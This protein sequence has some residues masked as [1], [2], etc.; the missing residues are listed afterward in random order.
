MGMWVGR[1]CWM[2]LPKLGCKRSTSGHVANSVAS[3]ERA[4]QPQRSLGGVRRPDSEEA[5]VDIVARPVAEAA[6]G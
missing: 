5:A 3:P 6:T 1:L 2:S 4:F